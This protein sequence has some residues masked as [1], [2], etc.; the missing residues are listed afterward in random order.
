MFKVSNITYCFA[1]LACILLV[2]GCG[3]DRQEAEPQKP[4]PDQYTLTY[5]A[6]EKG[7]IDGVSP[8]TVKHGSDGSPV[9]AVPAEHYHFTG[10]SDGVKSAGRTDTNVTADLSL[11]ANFAIDQYTLTYTAGEHGSIEG[12]STQAVD[13][14]DSGTEVSASPEDGYHF[15]SWSDGGL[16]SGDTQEVVVSC[17][18]PAGAVELLITPEETR[19]LVDL[20]EEMRGTTVEDLLD[21]EDA[22]P[23]ENDEDAES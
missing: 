19:E 16:N 1:A 13:H 6:G 14:G 17:G 15:V 18:M 10:W 8:Q 21:E 12:A 5:S 2:A 7:T 23:D 3:S 11:T 20:P 9:T 22:V 4:V